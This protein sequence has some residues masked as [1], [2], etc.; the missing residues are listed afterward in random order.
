MVGLLLR[1]ARRQA[2]TAYT[3]MLTTSRMKRPERAASTDRREK[4]LVGVR[5]GLGDDGG[6]VAAGGRQV[7]GIGD[8]RGVAVEVTFGERLTLYPRGGH[9]GNLNYRVNG[10]AMLEFFRG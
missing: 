1:R 5:R 8:R 4:P 7:E 2:G 10:D 9:C 6:G 3:R